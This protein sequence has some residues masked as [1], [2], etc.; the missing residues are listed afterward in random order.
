MWFHLELKN[1]G[2]AAARTA[3]AVADNPVGPYTYLRSYR[4]NAGVWPIQ[5]PDAWKQPLSGEDPLKWWTD[6]WK[7]AVTEGLFVRKDFTEGQMSRD[8]T[9]FVDD[10]GKAYHI[11]AS[12]E[13]LTLHIAELTDDYLSFTGKWAQIFPA[14]HNEAPALCKYSSKYYLITSG[15]TGWAPNA[16][17]SAV[18]NSIW[19]PWESLG[20]PC[21]GQGSETTFQ[22]Q[23]TYIIKVEGIKDGYIFMADRWT[24]R[25]PIDGSYIW[26]PLTFEN[27]KPTLK[28]YNQ[29]NL[30]VFRK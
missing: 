12:E 20:N 21:I 26:L 1:K 7:K 15:C 25:N 28:L 2:Y 17:R 6:N 9:V 10:D 22:S 29:W 13:N 23:S 11:H 24:P 19:G 27:N 14:G 30:S 16:A 8:M 5:Y 4:P 3:V 18:A